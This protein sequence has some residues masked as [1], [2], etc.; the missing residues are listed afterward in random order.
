MKSKDG[1][2][3]GEI[4]GTP[5]ARS[6]FA[7]LEIGMSRTQV[8]KLIGGPDDSASHITGRQFTPFYFGGDTQRHEAFY[9]NEGQL[10][11]T[12]RSRYGVPDTLLIIS[13][14]TKATGV[15]Q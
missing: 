9:R 3:D 2:V 5:A 4:F 15:R 13:V 8:E 7:K 14:D 1:K 6:K 10:T 11:Y 12:N